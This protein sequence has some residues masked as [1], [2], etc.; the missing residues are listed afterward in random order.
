MILVATS[1]DTGKA[2]LEGFRDV[3]GTKILVFYPENGVSEMQKRQ[4]QV[5]E[6]QNV[7]VCAIQG[8]FD[9]AQTGVKRIF[10]DPAV[11]AELQKRGM[12]FSSANSINWGRLLPQIVYYFSA[13][14]DLMRTGEMD[15]PG[16][17]INI[18]VPTG[19]FGN[20]L[21][22]F[23]AKQRGLPVNRLICASNENNV[24]TDFLRTGVYDRNRPFH[25]TISPS[26]DILVS[27]NLERL[28]FHLTDGDSARV[29]GWMKSL[30][31]TGRYEVDAQTLAKLRDL[32]WAGYCD[33]A[34][35]KNTIREMFQVENYL[36]DPHTAVAVHVYQQY[37]ETTGDLSTPTVVVS[38]ASPYKFAP[39]VLEA[40]SGQVSACD[41]FARV[42]ELSA[43]T[44]AP[45]PQP[46]LS[47]RGKPV[48]FTQSCAKEQMA[49]T[50]LSL[51]V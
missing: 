17:K 37:T 5:Q 39:S 12:M 38:T 47:L 30:N 34:A 1:G 45:V 50:V 26:M 44:G 40:V 51:L 22:A 48:R 21:A 18:V 23:Y 2:A 43:L 4:M 20:I 11:K 19:N 42:E 16:E 33:D 35:T 24:L 46:I 32:F 3:P 36:C 14:C 27:S 13:Y 41:D 10:T 8:N 15:H 25:T 6:G 49:Q 29:A 9:D 7:S 31:D 28:L